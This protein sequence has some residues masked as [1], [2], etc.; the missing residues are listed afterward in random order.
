MVQVTESKDFHARQTGL[1]ALTAG[2]SPRIISCKAIFNFDHRT[3]LLVDFTEDPKVTDSEHAC[4]RT[5]KQLF[6]VLIRDDCDCSKEL[7]LPLLPQISLQIRVLALEQ[8]SFKAVVS[9][10]FCSHHD[11][12]ERDLLIFFSNGS[13]NLTY[14]RRF[15]RGLRSDDLFGSIRLVVIMVVFVGLRD[16]VTVYRYLTLYHHTTSSRNIIQ[17]GI[18]RH[19]LIQ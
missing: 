5:F 16:G 8:E 1:P 14:D 13:M 4:V 9:T 10:F 6:R 12:G 19:F 7:K 11:K 15:S 17:N 18:I 2:L 3:P